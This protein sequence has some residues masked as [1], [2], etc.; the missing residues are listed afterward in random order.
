MPISKKN[1][2]TDNLYFW[3]FPTATEEFREKKEIVI[4]LNGG[5]GSF[6]PCLLIYCQSANKPITSPAAPLSSVLCKK[7]VPSCGK[8]AW[9]GRKGT[10]GLLI[11]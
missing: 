6:V 7:M 3:F 1:D 2:E 8:Q 9:T 4:W 5:V 11:F 10:L